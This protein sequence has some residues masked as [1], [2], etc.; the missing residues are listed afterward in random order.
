MGIKPKTGKEAEEMTKQSNEKVSEEDKGKVGLT[1]EE[2]KSQPLP[3]VKDKQGIKSALL[4]IIIL[5]IVLVA[6]VY[7]IINR[8]PAIGPSL[9]AFGIIPLIL[10]KLAGRRIG[11][12]GADITFGVIDSIILGIFTLG[13]ASL[14]GILGAVVGSGVG[15]SITNSIAGIFEGEVD[16]YLRRKNV[17]TERTPLSAGMGKISGSLIGIGF[18]LTIAWTIVGIA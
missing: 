4:Q 16:A 11:S 9:M 13:G 7:F 3:K 15:N 18:V 17:H 14:A 2:A 8:K 10:V 6:V 1:A 5:S 12:V